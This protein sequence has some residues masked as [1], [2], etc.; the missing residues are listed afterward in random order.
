MSIP[1]VHEQDAA[2]GGASILDLAALSATP[3]ERDPFDFLVGPSFVASE[4]LAAINAEY[5]DITEPG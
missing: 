4:S 5:P 3:L 1:A 2:G